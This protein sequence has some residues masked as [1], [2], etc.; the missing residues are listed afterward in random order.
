MKVKIG[1]TEVLCSNNFTINQEMLNTPSVILNNVYPAS[2]EDDKDYTSRF[3]HPD[4]YS[5]C[6]IYN[7]IA[8]EPGVEVTNNSITANVDTS[9]LYE[10][11]I[12]GGSIQSGTPSISTPEPIKTLTGSN[13]IY[14]YGDNLI[15]VDELSFVSGNLQNNGVISANTNYKT[16]DGYL[17]IS[18]LG[19]ETGDNFTFTLTNMYTTGSST[20]RRVLLYGENNNVLMLYLVKALL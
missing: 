18:D 2:W 8:A 6:K 7:E 5:Q 11:K 19:L 13:N 12:L 17:N 16:L 4:D 3:Y 14:V 1:N 15:N 20:T 10:Y 9:K